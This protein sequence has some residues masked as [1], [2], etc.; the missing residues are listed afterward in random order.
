M[1]AV[2][3]VRVLNG[4]ME[5]ASE[6]GQRVGSFSFIKVRVAVQ[7][8]SELLSCFTPPPSAPRGP[9]SKNDR[10]TCTLLTQSRAVRGAVLSG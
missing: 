1:H 2:E 7:L 9:L 4:N 5:C 3:E 8:V 6:S 10:Q